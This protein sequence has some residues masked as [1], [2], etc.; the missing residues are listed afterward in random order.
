MTLLLFCMTIMRAPTMPSPD[1]GGVDGA[2]SGQSVTYNTHQ[3]VLLYYKMCMF[4][5]DVYEMFLR[6]LK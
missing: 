2:A 4:I 5:Y 3:D 6:K 1:S